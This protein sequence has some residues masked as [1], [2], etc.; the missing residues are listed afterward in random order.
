MFELIFD[1]IL[2]QKN[3]N[4]SNCRALQFSDSKGNV[5]SIMLKV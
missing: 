3:V 1:N 5:F 2:V 4:Q